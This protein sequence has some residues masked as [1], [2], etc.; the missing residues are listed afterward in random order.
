MKKQMIK[1]ATSPEQ[2]FM[3][4]LVLLCLSLSVATTLYLIGIIDFACLLLVYFGGVWNYFAKINSYFGF[5]LCVLT[6]VFFGLECISVGLYAHSILYFVFYLALGFVVFLL[7]LK[8]NTI[9]VRY[10]KLSNKESYIIIALF[11]VLFVAG[12]AGALLSHNML[13][14]AMDI[15]CSSMLALSAYLHSRNYREYYV[16]RPIALVATILMF[17]YLIAINIINSAIITMLLIYIMYFLL[18]IVELIFL[19][20]SKY[21]VDKSI[22]NILPMSSMS[23]LQIQ[24]EIV[25]KEEVKLKKNRDHDISA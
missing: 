12:F 22:R 8:G 1:I 24:D 13:V 21:R 6:S 10:K 2:L 19:I 7:N 15:V 11:C 25:I 3:V 4:K 5:G 18:N 16:V 9:F 17:A 23:V 20:C 14:P